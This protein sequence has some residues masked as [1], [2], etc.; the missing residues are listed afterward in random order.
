MTNFKPGFYVVRS[1]HTDPVTKK[2]QSGDIAHI[3]TLNGEPVANRYYE[4]KPMKLAE[5][6]THWEVLNVIEAPSLE[7]A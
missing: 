6:L 2:L 4:H 7:T 3:H 1:R 5:F